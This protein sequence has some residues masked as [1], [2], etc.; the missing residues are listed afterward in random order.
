MNFH[1]ATIQLTPTLV[2]YVIVHELAHVHE[3]N[4]TPEFWLRVE[5]AMPEFQSVKTELASAGA[6]LWLGDATPVYEPAL[7]G[8][9]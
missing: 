5:R 4:H 2:D 8:S 3:P 6:R 7:E 1:W 9:R